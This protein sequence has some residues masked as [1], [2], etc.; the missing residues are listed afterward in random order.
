MFWEGI[1]I[2]FISTNP[3][4]NVKLKSDVNPCSNQ[5]CILNLKSISPPP[6]L[7]YIFPPNETYYEG[8]RAAGEKYSAFFCNF[9]NFKSIE[10]NICLLF[11]NWE[12]NIRFPPLIN[13]FQSFF[14]LHVIGHIFF[15]FIFF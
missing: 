13:P 10:E 2:H 14:P 1:N 5:G 4:S 15:I 12:K 9:V 8:V 6:F 11:T 7:I 3:S